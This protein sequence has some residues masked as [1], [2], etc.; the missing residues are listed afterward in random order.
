[1]SR[2]IGLAR[3]SAS[4]KRLL[5]A[6]L[7][8]FLAQGYND[9]GVQDVLRATDL[10]KGSFYHHFASKEA[11]GLLVVDRYVEEVHAELDRVLGDPSRKPLAR[12]RHFFERTRAT[13][14]SQGYRGCLF[15]ALGQELSGVSEAF[16]RKVESCL[17]RI[18]ERLAGCLELA[19]EAGDL[20][21]GTDTR[22]LAD[23]LVNCWEGA[24]LRSRLLRSPAPLEAM[25]NFCFSA[26]ATD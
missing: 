19:R 1:M 11:F 14:A 5:E 12:V 13:Y 21:P 20:P 3:E 17:A 26:I 6:G 18:V 15:G 8:L 7:E 24:A 4:R 10:P 23:L 2:P 22:G 16:R 9:T 25:L